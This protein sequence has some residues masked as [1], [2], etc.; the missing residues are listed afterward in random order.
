MGKGGFNTAD[1]PPKR[2][3]V[4]AGKQPQ[5]KPTHTCLEGSRKETPASDTQMGGEGTE[6]S[7]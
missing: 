3:A 7:S 4:L 2:N 5:V 1:W 6:Q